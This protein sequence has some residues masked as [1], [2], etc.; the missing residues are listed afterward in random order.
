ML[1]QRLSIWDHK[2]IRFFFFFLI[3][4]NVILRVNFQ[5]VSLCCFWSTRSNFIYKLINL[6]LLFV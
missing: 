5:V 6:F 3:L 4:I 1:P 2:N